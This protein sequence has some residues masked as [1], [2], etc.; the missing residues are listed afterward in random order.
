MSDDLEALIQNADDVM[1]PPQSLVERLKADLRSTYRAISASARPTNQRD[2]M[3]FLALRKSQ[4]S[5]SNKV[6][7]V[8]REH[9]LAEAALTLECADSSEPS[10]GPRLYGEVVLDVALQTGSVGRAQFR[11]SRVGIAVGI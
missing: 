1:A 5:W 11:L 9:G 10:A 8:R 4:R 3:A 2:R 6:R 7:Q